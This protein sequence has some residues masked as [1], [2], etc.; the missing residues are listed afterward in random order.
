MLVRIAYHP[1]HAWDGG[2]FFGSPLRVAAR[3]QNLAARILAVNAPDGGPCVM[4]RRCRY[5]AGIEDDDLGLVEALCAAQTAFFELTLDGRTIR[6]GGATA[7][8]FHEKARHTEYYSD[9]D[10]AVWGCGETIH[11]VFTT[12]SA[13][14]CISQNLFAVSYPWS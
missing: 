6:L 12:V 4:I 3:D 13:S 7:E 8:V 2:E 5:R 1:V 14:I 9:S 11:V 10:S